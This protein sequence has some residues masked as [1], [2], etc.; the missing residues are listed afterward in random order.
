MLTTLRP[1]RKPASTQYLHIVFEPKFDI[2]SLTVT[3]ISHL[4]FAAILYCPLLLSVGLHES[5]VAVFQ[6]HPYL[7]N[8]KRCKQFLMTCVDTPASDQQER[9]EPH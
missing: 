2:L 4:I 8:S 7:S 3:H 1:N 6:E 5:S 9:H